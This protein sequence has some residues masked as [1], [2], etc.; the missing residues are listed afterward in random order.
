MYTYQLTGKIHPERVNFTIGTK[1]PLFIEH[2]S[3]EIK[4]E[5]LLEI[6]DSNIFISF[7]SSTK[8]SSSDTGCTGPLSLH[9]I[10]VS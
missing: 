3:F 10:L 2:T 9:A 5:I 1:L 6:K 8:Y 4:G 7:N